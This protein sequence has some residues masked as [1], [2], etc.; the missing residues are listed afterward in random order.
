MPTP[1]KPTRHKTA[2]AL[3]LLAATTAHA[4]PQPPSIPLIPTANFVTNVQV[5]LLQYPEGL[6]SWKNF[7]FVGTYNIANPTQTRVFVFDLTN[8]HLINT[9]GATPATQLISQGADLGLTINPATGDLFVNANQA[10]NVLRVQHPTLPNAAASIY[11]SYPTNTPFPPGPE[12]MAWDNTTGWLY[13]SDS[14]NGFIYAIPPGGGT[15]I[16]MF[17]PAGSGA[18]YSDNGLFAQHVP[19]GGLSPNGLVF[20]LDYKTLY[21][22]NTDADSILAIPFG[23]DGMPTGQ[24]HTLA[25]NLNNDLMVDPS[26]FESLRFPDTRIGISAGTPLNGPDGLAIDALGNIWAANAFSDSLT[27]VDPATGRIEGSIG[28]SAATSNGLL[29]QPASLTFAGGRVYVTNLNLFG[30]A[31]GVTS[32]AVGVPGAGGNG[33]R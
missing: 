23:A 3:T 18:R 21:A 1:T 15:P 30:N 5:P 4:A 7:L 11:A 16:L 20:S 25:Q 12:D 28:S 33:N 9:L 19:G 2:L 24:I 14:N 31:W 10:G 13:D 8:G 6:T 29:D 27:I 26:G 17:G 32:F 22:A